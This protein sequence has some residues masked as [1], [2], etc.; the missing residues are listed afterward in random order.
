MSHLVTPRGFRAGKTQNWLN[1]TLQTNKISGGNLT[2]V[3]GLEK[4]CRRL[5]KKKRLYLVN[6]ALTSIANKKNEYRILFAPKIKIRPNTRV[7]GTL[8]R[9]FVFRPIE[10]EIRSAVL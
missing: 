2:T 4:L 8:G 9:K 5:M 6:T 10:P 3:Y 1:N 7:T